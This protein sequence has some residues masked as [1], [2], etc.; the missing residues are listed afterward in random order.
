MI[1]FRSSTNRVIII[2][3][4][5]FHRTQVHLPV[6][7]ETTWAII[8]TSFAQQ[9]QRIGHLMASRLQMWKRNVFSFNK[10]DWISYL[11][12]IESFLLLLYLLLEFLSFD[13][14]KMKQEEDS[15]LKRINNLTKAIQIPITTAMQEG[16]MVIITLIFRGRQRKDPQRYMIYYNF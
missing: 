1:I 2:L 9:R 12:I 7:A 15:H 3:I 14:H 4:H 16:I 8:I 10:I 13:L 11:V 5:H 6:I